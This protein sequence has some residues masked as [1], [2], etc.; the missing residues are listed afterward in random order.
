M[1]IFPG[2]KTQLLTNINKRLNNILK[3]YNEQQ[4]L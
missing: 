2:L 1:D 4:C 3:N